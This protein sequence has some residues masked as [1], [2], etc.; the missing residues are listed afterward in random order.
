MNN[1]NRAIGYFP[2]S[3]FKRT[4]R[5]KLNKN[6]Y[7]YRIRKGSTIGPFKTQIQALSDLDCFI[8]TIS[9]TENR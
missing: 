7:Y 1:G 4:N 3:F 6:G 9:S 8:R 2:A 5:V